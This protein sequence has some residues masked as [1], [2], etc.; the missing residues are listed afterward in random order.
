[1]ESIYN[2]ELYSEQHTAY[3]CADEK[4]T[5]L[6]QNEKGRQGRNHTVCSMS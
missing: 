2:G 5:K 3:M 1:M 6:S 4:E